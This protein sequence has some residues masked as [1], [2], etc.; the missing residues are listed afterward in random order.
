MLSLSSCAKP[1]RSLLATMERPKHAHTD[2]LRTV[3]LQETNAVVI[4]A[5]VAMVIQAVEIAFTDTQHAG[6]FRNA[7]ALRAPL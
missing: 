7:H 5:A 4:R 1:R 2:L 3:F 6:D